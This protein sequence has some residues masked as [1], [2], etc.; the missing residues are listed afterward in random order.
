MDKK[1]LALLFYWQNKGIDT[2]V[3]RIMTRFAIGI[4]IGAG[5]AGFLAGGM[6]F[7][8]AKSDQG[9]FS[10][11]FSIKNPLAASMKESTPEER[12]AEALARSRNIKG[13][14]MTADVAM[15]PGVGASRLR[16]NLIKLADETEINGLVIDVKEVCG[17]DYDEERLK[18]LIEELKTKNIWTIGRIVLSKDASQIDVHPEWYLTRKAGANS[19]A[20]ECAR[21]A[22]I[23]AARPD[24]KK[25]SV[26]FWRDRR[27]G[28]WMDPAHPEVHAYILEFSKRM[29]DMGFDE[30]QFDYIRFPSDG[31]IENA[32]YPAYDGKT[33]KYAVMKEYF[34]FL[35]K[36]LKAHKPEIVLSADLFGYAAIRAGDVG[37]GQRVDDVGD[38]FDYI[39][40]MTYPSHYYNGL[41]LPEDPTR[42]LPALRYDA[43]QAR[44]NPDIVV[45]RTLQVARDFLDGKIST[46]SFRYITTLSA[47]TSTTTVS[48]IIEQKSRSR[49]RLRPWLEDFYH[50]ADATAGRPSGAK[51]VRMQIDAAETVD[52]SG[53]LLWSAANVYTED[54][55]K[56]E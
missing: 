36:N 53:W 44:T 6:Y 45:L 35:N 8:F 9:D 55:L 47:T 52:N 20:N 34:E 48:A 21:K 39:S 17:P 13:L 27:G 37:I 51:K 46:S 33:P 25:A 10:F 56:K 19:G 22:H 30:L 1:A 24:G 49:A 14:Y 29:I 3:I 54:A 26:N 32:I 43:V 42:G 4:V 23:R 18:K 2:I 41:H 38:N 5:I 50:E 12:A 7:Y 15:D 16:E 31:D 40:F 11:P 28:Y